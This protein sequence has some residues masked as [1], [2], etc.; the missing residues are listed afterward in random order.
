MTDFD[1]TQAEQS[2][3]YEILKKLGNKN[4]FDK[5]MFI[6]NVQSFPSNK[7]RLFFVYFVAFLLDLLFRHKFSKQS[8]IKLKQKAS[9]FETFSNIS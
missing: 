4:D 2:A 8:N 1:N 3:N 7:S 9:T 5:K 6:E